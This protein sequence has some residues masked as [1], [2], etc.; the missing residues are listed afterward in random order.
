ME[1]RVCIS[2]RLAGLESADSNE[3]RVAEILFSIQTLQALALRAG[4]LNNV[5]MSFWRSF[6]LEFLRSPTDKVDKQRL[7]DMAAEYITNSDWHNGVL[8]E[9]YVNSFFLLMELKLEGYRVFL[10]NNDSGV[11]GLG[12]WP[13]ETEWYLPLACHVH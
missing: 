10:P 6:V 1:T 4:D 5:R 12:I 11:S 2:S 3:E 13:L 7:L 8:P 9:T